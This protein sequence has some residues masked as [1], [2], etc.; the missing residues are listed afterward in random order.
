MVCLKRT[1][2]CIFTSCLTPLSISIT[3]DCFFQPAGECNLVYL[4]QHF[5]LPL[6]YEES[7]SVPR[8]NPTDKA[9]SQNPHHICQHSLLVLHSLS[10]RRDYF[11]SHHSP[12]QIGYQSDFS[13]HI[14]SLITLT[15][16]NLLDISFTS[17][18]AVKP[19]ITCYALFNFFVFIA[20][21]LFSTICKSGFTVIIWLAFNFDSFNNGWFDCRTLLKVGFPYYIYHFQS[22]FQR[23]HG[24]VHR[25]LHF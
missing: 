9:I 8:I 22:Q 19:R 11:D 25:P 3:F 12:H 1:S 6:P 17:V 21:L 23:P 18:M 5:L 13:W 4:I 10:F 16:C 14:R 24:H 20:D 2:C 7:L 15:I